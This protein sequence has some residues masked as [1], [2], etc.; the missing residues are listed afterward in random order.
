[1]TKI[2]RYAPVAVGVLIAIP[3]L[4]SR[5]LPMSDLPMHEGVVG[6]LRHFGDPAY[7]PDGL[8][9]LNLWH[10]NQLFHLSAAALSFVV[11]TSAACRIVVAAAQILMFVGGA[12]LA[13]YLG[14]SR[15][16]VILLAPLALGFTFYWGLVA[17][18]IGFASFL[19]A[20]P[21]ID[22]AARE[23]SVK[24]TAKASAFFV[25]LFFAHET[26]FF[27][28]ALVVGVFTILRP[29]SWRETPL[30][31][32]PAFFAFCI[33][34]AHLLWEDQFFT[35]GQ[36]KAPVGF[37]TPWARVRFFPNALFGSYEMV[38]Q[39]LLLGMSL[40]G[41]G[42]L[43]QARIREAKDQPVTPSQEALPVGRLRRGRAFLDR[44][45]FELVAV[46]HFVGYS[47]CPFN[48]RGATLLHERFLG[49]AWA[50]LVIV[51][52]PRVTVPRLARLVPFVVPVGILLLCWPQFADADRTYRDLDAIIERIPKNVAVTQASLDRPAFLTRTYSAATAPARIIADRGGRI[53]VSLMI[54]PISAVQLVP[55]WRWDEYDFRTTYKGSKMLKPAHDLEYFEYVVAQ[56]RDPETRDWIKIALSPEADFITAKG[57]WLLFHSK[58]KV[59][60]LKSKEVPPPEGM[61]TAL[62][63]IYQLSQI[64]AQALDEAEQRQRAA[65][66]QK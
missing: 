35:K 20:L 11:S 3:T 42:L 19:W 33:A 13:D 40:L 27:F 58:K 31:I 61:E 10:P 62:D 60:P 36:L 44:Y 46:L 14:R 12:R 66:G 41:I 49:P 32:F 50:L 2:D 23:P 64:H 25:L 18:L 24:N 22:R 51:V 45:R 55:E 53:G 34:L 63:R 48:W 56:S 7:M 16:G 21:L 9:R 38:E 65:E 4:L 57:E 47:I 54:S 15:A 6:L 5:Y 28:T 1:V 8:Y 43:L 37:F 39:L 30:R 52:A 26:V 29:L 17:N 59:L